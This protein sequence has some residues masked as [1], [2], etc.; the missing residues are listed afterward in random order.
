[1]KNKFCLGLIC[2]MAVSALVS[3]LGKKV[4]A[5]VDDFIDTLGVLTAF[6]D[7]TYDEGERHI[8]RRAYSNLSTLLSDLQSGNLDYA[9]FPSVMANYLLKKYDYLERVGF[10]DGTE[11]FCIG[12]PPRNEDLLDEINLAIEELEDN[13]IID[14]LT[15]E[16]LNGNEKNYK[17]VKFEEFEGAQT[18]TF[19]VTGNIPPI[20]YVND[21]GVFSGFTTAFLSELGKKL[22]KNIKL[23][24]CEPGARPAMLLSR[25]ADALFWVTIMSNEDLHPESFN[26]DGVLLSNPY[27]SG[28][29]EKL[30]L[31]TQ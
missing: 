20:D 28:P 6:N 12:V 2:A 9:Q 31:K 21:E 1:M 8:Q 11:S 19:A 4:E 14:N 18:I 25:K 13:K 23:I 10:I 7:A 5:P 24:S 3:C 15:E 27:L 30:K 22:K 26:M 17:E 16:Y 29:I